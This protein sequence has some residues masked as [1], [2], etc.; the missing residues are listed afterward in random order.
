MSVTIAEPVRRW[1]EEIAEL[2][3]QPPASAASNLLAAMRDLM[4]LELRRIPLR[5]QEA[6]CLADILNSSITTAVLGPITYAEVSDAFRCA[7]DGVSSYGAK[8][9]IDEE[10]LLKKLKDIG[11]A[12]DL[13]LRLAFAR[14][15]AMSPDKRDYRA[16]GIVL[17][18]VSR[19]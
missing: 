1:L 5:E 7:G 16:V 11:P 17:S 19:S 14:W 6:D 8:H 2:L 12:A 9:G 4:R 3:M 13:A 15:W 10:A 18:E